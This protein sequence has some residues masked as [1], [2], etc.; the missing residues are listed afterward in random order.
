MTVMVTTKKCR[1]CKET[2]P[3]EDF[4]KTDHGGTHGVE[5]SCRECRKKAQLICYYKDKTKNPAKY[6]DPKRKAEHNRKERERR[7]NHPERRKK[8]ADR[9]KAYLMT[10]EGKQK[11]NAYQRKRMNDPAHRIRQRLSKR[12]RKALDSVMVG[13]KVLKTMEM[14]GCSIPVFL[15]HLE[16]LFKPGMTWDNYGHGKDRWQMDHILPCAAFD[17]TDPEQ[18]RKCFHY[19]NIQPMWMIDNIKKGCKLPDQLAPTAVI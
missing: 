3:L 7:A 15:N 5:G 8:E 11:R 16:S 1:T 6:Q 17:L 4:R 9:Q 19:T 14:L 2:K 13:K 12:L 10:E 18:Q